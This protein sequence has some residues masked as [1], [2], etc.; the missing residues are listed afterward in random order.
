M[1]YQVQKN[2]SDEIEELQAYIDVLPERDSVV[3]PW[4]NLVVNFNVVTKAHRDTGDKGLCGIFVLG[5]FTGGELVLY[6]QRLVLPLQS[7]HFVVF[8]SKHSTHFNMHCKGW[9]TSFVLQTDS[10]LDKWVHKK[11]NMGDFVE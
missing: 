6:E 10:K 8:D 5:E 7:G 11:N 9:R 3:K 4:T 2:L 1:F